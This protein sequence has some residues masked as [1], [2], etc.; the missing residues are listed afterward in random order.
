[1]I[2]K[3][4]HNVI[5]EKDRDEQIKNNKTYL[6][7]KQKNPDWE[8]MIWNEEMILKLL[9]K[10]PKIK[11]LYN[12]LNTTSQPNPQE[13]QEIMENKKRIASYVILKENGGV[14]QENITPTLSCSLDFNRLFS[15]PNNDSN[16]DHYDRSYHHSNNNNNNN[17]TI[18][19]KDESKIESDFSPFYIS[20]NETNS[21]LWK[22]IVQHLLYYIYPFHFPPIFTND[23]IACSKNH[24][25]IK[26]I[27]EKL[28][29]TLQP[30]HIHEILNETLD[31]NIK[32]TVFPLKKSSSGSCFQIDESS[33]HYYKP[34]DTTSGTGGFSLYPVFQKS[35]LFF[36]C[37]YK[38]IYL[39]LL[40]IFIVYTIHHISLYNSNH[41]MLSNSFPFLPGSSAPSLASANEP[42]PSTSSSSKRRKKN[43]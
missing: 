24:P 11:N 25:I 27:V 6:S 39:I 35:V 37:Y 5:I 38:K 17:N 30:S 21:E 16:N 12:K 32:Y 18:N 40:S 2:P 15:D 41:G 13:L 9:E 28:K 23:M 31:C 7:M 34:T 19:I 3:I 22:D 42:K 33:F 14:Y 26:E 43:G 4:I 1:M 10:Y 36:H 8:F 29:V 20:L